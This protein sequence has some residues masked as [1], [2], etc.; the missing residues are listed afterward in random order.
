MEVWRIISINAAVTTIF[1]TIV[2]GVTLFLM[3]RWVSG[4]DRF[5]MDMIKLIQDIKVE[6]S[7]IR[8][9][10]IKREDFDSYRQESRDSRQSLWKELKDLDH[11]YGKEVEVIK[12][13]ISAI[14][15]EMRNG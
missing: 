10:Y 13:R 5:M 12:E 2:G 3:K 14:K 6:V 11:V 15:E 8:L 7:S 4:V 9:E 1:A